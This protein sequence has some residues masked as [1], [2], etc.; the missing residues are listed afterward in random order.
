MSCLPKYSSV[1]YDAQRQAQ[2][3]RERVAREEAQRR[4]R[5]E[6]WRR[7]E[8]EQ[9]VARQ[10]RASAAL[11]EA[12]ADLTALAARARV[13]D[14]EQSIVGPLRARADEIAQHIARDSGAGSYASAVKLQTDIGH[15]L[16]AVDATITTR[17]LRQETIT[18]LASGLTR[19]GFHV[20]TPAVGASGSLAVRA[21]FGDAEIVDIAVYQE[22]DE[23]KVALRRHG[24]ATVTLELFAKLSSE[25]RSAGLEFG[26]VW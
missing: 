20:S 26:D 6:A 21:R 13:L 2:E 16:T 10:V 12:R 1:Q 19:R 14:V 24:E 25:A 3:A 7:A 9:R 4:A 11:A 5:E 22:G 18:A 23:Q 15:T 17:T 8:R